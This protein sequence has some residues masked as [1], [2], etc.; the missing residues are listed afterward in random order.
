M[1]PLHY[2]ESL[3]VWI[4]TKS[5]PKF[6]PLMQ[7]IHTDVCIVGGGIGGLTTA[8]LLAKEGKKVCVLESFEL[9]SGQTGKT[10]AHFSNV[11]D[12]RYFQLEKYHGTEGLKLAI[13]SHTTAINRVT[14]IVA[15]ENIECELER[16][17]GYLFS[18]NDEA[19]LQKE[20][21]AADRAGHTAIELLKASPLTNFDTGPCLLFPRQLQL[22]PLKYLSALTKAILQMGGKIFTHTQ[23]THVEGGANARVVTDMNY[24]VSCDAVVVAT[25]TP[26]NDRLAIHTKQASYRSYVLGFRV[27]TGSIEKG[28]YWDTMNPYHYFRI[29]SQRT[30]DILM[31]GGEDHKTGQE[32]DPQSCY[33]RLEIWARK[34]FPMISDPVYQWSGQVMETMDGLAYLGHNP[35]DKDNVYIITGDSGNGMTHCTIGAMLITDQIMGRANPWEKLYNPSRITLMAAPAFMKENANTAAQ[36]AQ[37]LE[38][39]PIPDFDNI[40][41]DSGITFRDGTQMMAAYKEASG[42]LVYISAVCPHLGGIVN[43]N[44]AEKSWDCPCHGSRFD[45]KGKV[46]EGPAF[47]DLKKV[48]FVWPIPTVE[49]TKGTEQFLN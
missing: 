12:D 39:K 38:F 14:E 46:I 11:L 31:V 4:D 42:N 9:A 15:I 43:W 27:P 32:D 47:T 20:L 29:E 49:L 3:S 23:V 48:D 17:N 41:N 36:Y 45:C 44:N 19:L 22:H 40:P 35:M 6:S 37:W 5:M 24:E 25:N 33:S 34:R 30:C 18:Y 7:N 21:A 16:V 13:E 10:T 28:L 8:Y 1:N 2:G 26:I